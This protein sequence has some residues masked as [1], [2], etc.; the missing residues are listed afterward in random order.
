MTGFHEIRLPLAAS[1]GAVGGP[2]RQTE[3]FRLASGAESRNARWSGSR[4]KWDVGGT[5]MRLDTAHDLVDF[6]EAWERG[7]DLLWR[8]GAPSGVSGR[9]WTD[10]QAFN[11][12]AQKEWS[13]A[14]LRPSWSGGDLTVTWVRRAR[15]DGDP[16]VAGELPVILPE[17]FSVR[18]SGWGGARVWETDAP[19]AVYPEAERI[20]D[21][22]AGG[23]ALIEAGQFGADGQAGALAAQEVAIPAP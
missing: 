21:F 9:L 11:A 22:A 4:G 7:L 5:V 1:M 16:W 2:D 10:T 12:V 17:R 15:R 23:I 14:H 19:L 13:P 20:A 18:I 8:V 6:F 3:I